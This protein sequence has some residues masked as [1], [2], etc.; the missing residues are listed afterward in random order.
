MAGSDTMSSENPP[1]YETDERGEILVL[2]V[3]K[4]LKSHPEIVRRGLQLEPVLPF[5]IGI[6][7]LT[8]HLQ[9]P[10]YVVKVL[11]TSTEE[12]EIYER[13]WQA[14][15][16]HNHTIPGEITPPDAGHPILITPYLTDCSLTCVLKP[17][18]SD[19]LGLF[20][21]LLEGIEY[22]HTLRI[23]HMDL[24]PDNIVITSHLAEQPRPDLIPNRVYI[25]DYG[26]SRQLA[27]GPGSQ[28]AITIGPSQVYL[29][30]PPGDLK[31]FDPYSW[32]IYCASHTMRQLF[33]VCFF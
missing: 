26:S 32:D 19:T 21:Q 13:L 29:V 30:H 17:N 18:P 15:S 25:I 24:C 2:E 5:K 14:P 7:Y 31:H 4:R 9:P 1:W 23:A 16:P 8:S 6:V 12:R 27:L 33:D 3:P 10:Q 20:V 28:P 11:D 22:M